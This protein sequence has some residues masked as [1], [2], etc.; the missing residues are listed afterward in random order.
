[1][2]ASDSG[3]VGTPPAR[4]PPAARCRRSAARS[5]SSTTM[6]SAVFLPMPG[7]RV[8]AVTSPACTSRAN[9][10]TLTP[11]S[12]ASAI[13]APMPLTFCTSRNSRRSALAQEAVQRHAV[14]LLRVVGEQRHLAADRRAGRRTCSSA[15]PARSRRR[16]RRSTSHG[17]CLWTRMPFRRPIMSSR[18]SA[19]LRARRRPVAPRSRARARG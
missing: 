3:S 11:D 14:L 8:S 13:F 15:P 7:M 6:R 10:S 16:A 9:S 19:R 4:R 5:R 1:M 12:T 2:V 17:G 18:V